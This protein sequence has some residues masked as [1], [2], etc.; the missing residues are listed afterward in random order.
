M[1]E[2]HNVVS[3]YSDLS[4][5]CPHRPKFSGYVRSEPHSLQQRGTNPSLSDAPKPE[6]SSKTAWYTIQI[7]DNIIQLTLLST[8]SML[9]V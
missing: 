1:P 8:C 5:H 4:E 3:G 7:G 6:I 9:I 2:M